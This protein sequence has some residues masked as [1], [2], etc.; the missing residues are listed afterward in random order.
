MNTNLASKER[1]DYQHTA[2]EVHS[3]EMMEK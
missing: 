3:R 2:M 1:Y